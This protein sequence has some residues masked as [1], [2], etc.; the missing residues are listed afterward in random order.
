LHFQLAKSQF[1]WSGCL[2]FIVFADLIKMEALLIDLHEASKIFADV[3]TI[4]VKVQG[5][6]GDKALSGCN[7]Q[8]VDEMPTR[9]ICNFC[10]EAM[11]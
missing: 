7:L 1:N 6:C 11:D 8:P 5:M 9:R 3:L 4:Q 10:L 2:K